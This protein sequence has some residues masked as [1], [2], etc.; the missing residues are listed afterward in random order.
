MSGNIDIIII[1]SAESKPYRA[2]L[3]FDVGAHPLFPAQGVA[4]PSCRKT[5]QHS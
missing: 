4:D 2:V 5:Q 1:N 3:V